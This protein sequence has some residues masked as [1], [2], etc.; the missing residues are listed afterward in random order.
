LRI[1]GR[2]HGGCTGGDAVELAVR[3]HHRAIGQR[4]YR[5]ANTV[6]AVATQ[7]L[8]FALFAWVSF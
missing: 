3:Q 6:P 1:S 7:G 4:R 5:T 2:N 8:N